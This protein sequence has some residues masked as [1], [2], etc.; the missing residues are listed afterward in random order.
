MLV[1]S[2][3]SCNN[4]AS[5]DN[6][7]CD[8]QRWHPAAWPLDAT[9]QLQHHIAVTA[10]CATTSCNKLAATLSCNK[11]SCNSQMQHT[12]KF[13]RCEKIGLL[14]FYWFKNQISW[15]HCQRGML[16]KNLWFMKNHFN[17]KTDDLWTWKMIVLNLQSNLWDYCK[18]QELVRRRANWN[19]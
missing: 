6:N 5:C 14:H 18:M 1:S 2:D 8:T 16:L 13:L 19:S 7:G 15:K 11:P 10:S 9:S 12:R 4:A 17:S 3:H